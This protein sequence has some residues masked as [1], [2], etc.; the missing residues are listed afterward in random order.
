MNQKT[1]ALEKKKSFVPLKWTDYEKLSQKERESYNVQEK[2]YNFE[3][4]MKRK[5][6]GVGPEKSAQ[7]LSKYF[8]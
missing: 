3:R 8:Q 5:G 1:K 6:Y 2:E 4:K 7:K